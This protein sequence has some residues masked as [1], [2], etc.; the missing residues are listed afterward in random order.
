MS[1]LKEWCSK[2]RGNLAGLA[3]HLDTS[4]GYLCEI[5]EDIKP[6][7]THMIRSIS[8]YTGI[9]ARELRPDLWEIFKDDFNNLRQQN[10]DI[11]QK[12]I[13]MERD[14]QGL[15]EVEIVPSHTFYSGD[16]K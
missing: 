7:P 15:P 13:K 3:E 6:L 9:P 16:Y 1:A 10:N 8:A 4:A 12:L 11:N 5:K 14:R 2:R